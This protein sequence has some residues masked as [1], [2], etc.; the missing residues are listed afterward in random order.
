MAKYTEAEWLSLKNDFELALTW[1]QI[2]IL[3]GKKFN[4]HTGNQSGHQ[5]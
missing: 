5:L 1:T 3:S 2:D 4:Q